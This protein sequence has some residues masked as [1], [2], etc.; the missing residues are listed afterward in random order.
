MKTLTLTPILLSLAA[1]T[2]LQAAISYSGTQNV[3]ISNTFTSLYLDFDDPLD[4]T[5][6]TTSSSEPGSWDINTFFGGTAFGNSDTFLVST[7]DG[8]VNS[9]LQNLSLTVVVGDGLG[10][11]ENFVASFSGSSDHMGSEF[12]NGV[13][14]YF[15]FQIYDGVG[16]YYF[17]WMRVTFFDDGSTGVLHEWAWDTSGAAIQVGAVPEPGS[18]GLLALGAGSLLVLRRRRS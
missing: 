11:G 9:T 7:D 18:L 13:A 15:G 8:T 4:A 5:S 14:G 2:P 10:E 1:A 6:F 17:G 3:V 12:T 16:D